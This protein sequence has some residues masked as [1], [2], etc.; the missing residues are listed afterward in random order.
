MENLKR[1]R[2][3]ALDRRHSYQK[4]G[5]GYFDRP[6]TLNIPKGENCAAQNIIRLKRLWLAAGS[7]HA[8]LMMTGTPLVVITLQ[9]RQGC[10]VMSHG[11]Q[12]TKR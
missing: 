1:Q 3:D 10:H 12:P 5:S 9:I 7:L 6:Q 11:Y 2:R 8:G 4:K